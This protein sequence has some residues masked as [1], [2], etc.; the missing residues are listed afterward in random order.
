MA[1][2]IKHEKYT[3]LHVYLQP[4]SKRPPPTKKIGSNFSVVVAL[5]RPLPSL[6]L[7]LLAILSTAFFSPPR[8]SQALRGPAN[9][10]C[11]DRPS[12]VSAR[13]S[14]NFCT[15]LTPLRADIVG[16]HACFSPSAVFQSN[17]LT[18]VT[19]CTW[20]RAGCSWIMT[21]SLLVSWLSELTGRRVYLVEAT[22]NPLKAYTGWSGL[23]YSNGVV[24]LIMQSRNGDGTNIY[25][26]PGTEGGWEHC[27]ISQRSDI[28][29][30]Q[31][32]S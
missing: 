23:F 7:M 4:S 27:W 10:P 32:Y 16:V 8:V 2:G 12:P 25:S 29:P 14:N 22:V 1:T 6:S 9:L 11:C 30:F 15:K 21:D 26:S 17:D 24:R 5:H 20:P 18:H 31:R 19:C 13:Y 28:C 3:H